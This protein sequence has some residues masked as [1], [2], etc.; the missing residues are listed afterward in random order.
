MIY[1]PLPVRVMVITLL[2][3]LLF[4]VYLLVDVTSHI[5]RFERVVWS[6]E[7]E[8]G[9][10]PEE[11]YGLEVDPDGWAYITDTETA[12]VTTIS[13]AGDVGK[14]PVLAEAPSH[15]AAV[16][17]WFFL[18]CSSSDTISRYC[19]EEIRA[20][21]SAR[22]EA[23][24]SLTDAL[25][26]TVRGI[27]EVGAPEGVEFWVDLTRVDKSEDGSL[28]LMA[29]LLSDARIY[30]LVLQGRVSDSTEE[31]L[32][33]LQCVYAAS[34]G[35]EDSL[36]MEYL[37]ECNH[38]EH[39][40]LDMSVCAS[41]RNDGGPTRWRVESRVDGSSIAWTGVHP[42]RPHI[43]GPAPAGDWWLAERRPLPR[44]RLRSTAFSSEWV[45]Y[46]VSTTGQVRETVRIQWP[47]GMRGGPVARS[48]GDLLYILY[49]AGETGELTLRVFEYS[50]RIEVRF[51]ERGLRNAAH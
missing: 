47:E 14:S 49:P 4:A 6:G 2:A 41:L 1:S 19:I 9:F 29:D 50:R 51:S 38:T 40:V 37:P 21:D 16:G 26:E 13:P 39:P 43:I 20:G 46:W 3:L 33:A 35:P 25:L 34:V 32:G 44:A 5:D 48:L 23:A 45:F 11:Y 28:L 27:G 17:E 36:W 10:S 15:P 22:P 31:V 30:R 12:A 7:G 8:H 18:H 24:R 42:V